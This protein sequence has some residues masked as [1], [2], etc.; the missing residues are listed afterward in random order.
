MV[1]CTINSSRVNSRPHLATT[2]P[3]F[4]P[5]CCV[6]LFVCKKGALSDKNTR[7]EEGLRH[8]ICAGNC[9]ALRSWCH[10]KTNEAALARRWG[11]RRVATR[12]CDMRGDGR[13]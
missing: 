4:A 7:V 5:S 9:A 10:A 13:N 6:K 2:L 8:C 1:E 11:V 3:D 12:D